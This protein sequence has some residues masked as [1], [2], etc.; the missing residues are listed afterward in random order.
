MHV[1]V[2]QPEVLALLERV[3]ASVAREGLGTIVFPRH[4]ADQ[5]ILRVY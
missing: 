1:L 5:V 3:P 2:M 4:G